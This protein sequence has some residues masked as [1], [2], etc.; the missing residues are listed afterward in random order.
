MGP[1]W[2]VTQRMLRYAAALNR[3]WM[4]GDLSVG[5]MSL[6]YT[7]LLSLI[8]L[9]VCNYALLH[10]IVAGAA[11]RIVVD[12]SVLPLG[13]SPLMSDSWGSIALCVG[14]PSVFTFMYSCIPNTEVE[15]L[16]VLIGGVTVGIM[17]ALVGKVFTAVIVYSSQLVAVYTGFDIVLT[18][19]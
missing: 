18:T 10:C 12:D 7:T 17:W 2:R 11:L 13:R 14:G 3:D 1:P 9:L 15:F 19:L 5:A 6:A 16:A 4:G 8:P